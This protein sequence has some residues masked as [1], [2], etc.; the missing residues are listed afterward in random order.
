MSNIP[1][2]SPLQLGEEQE[3]SFRT[4]KAHWGYYA[5]ATDIA[6][7]AAETQVAILMSVLGPKAILL[8]HDLGLTE[9]EKKS[10]AAILQKLELKLTPQREKRTERTE[11]RNMKQLPEESYD[12][13]LKRLRNKVKHCAF[14]AAE[15]KEELKEQFVKGIR[16]SE[17]RKQLLRDEALSL[18]QMV[19]KAN[20]EK[21]IDEL[22]EAYDQLHCDPGEGGSKSALKVTTTKRL[23]KNC[24]FCGSLHGRKKE[25][26]PAWG[27]KCRKC[28]RMNHFES[29][30]KSGPKF[31]KAPK[32][33]K[34][35]RRGTVRKVEEETTSS[36]SD[37]SDIE[38]S[39][40]VDIFSVEKKS[41]SQMK[42]VVSLEVG[43]GYATT[44]KCQAD[45]GAMVNIISLRDLHKCV[46]KPSMAPTKVKL[47]CFGGQVIVP[48]GKVELPVRLK[49]KR[50]VLSFVV[51]KS[52]QK[53][54]LSASACITLGVIKVEHVGSVEVMLN[55]C[56][57]IVKEFDDVFDGD[58]CFDG[59]FKIEVDESVRPVQQK[60]RRIPVAYMGELKKT[61][62]DLEVR[63]I[64]EPVN[65]HAEWISNL[66]LVKR[67]SKLRLCLDPSELNSAIKRTRHQIPTVEEMLP[68]LQNAKVFSVLDAKNG[69][70]HLKLDD[71]SSEL[72]TFWTPFGT[73]RWMRMPFGISAA[74]EMF[75]KE[76]QQI[77]CGLKGT[78]CIADDILI[79]GVGD[80]MTEALEDHNRNLKAALV[81][82]RERGL[83]IN[84]SKMK[85]AMTEVPFFGHILTNTGVK[86]DPQKV[87]AVAEIESPKTKKELHTFL[88]LATYLGKFLPS[89]SEICAP[90]RN[91]VK[92]D[93][94]FVWNEQAESSFEQLKQLAVTA[95]VLRYFDRREKLTI[96][97][98]ASKA[99]VGCVLLQNGQPVVYGSRTLT[100]AESNYACIERECLAIVFACKR[101]EQ[102]VVGMPGVVVETD[103][104]PLVEIFKKPIHTAP[105]RLQRMMLALK[106][107]VVTVTYR[108]GS[109]MH[110]A[111]LL[112]RTAKRASTE[113]VDNEFEIYAIKSTESLLEYFA[114]INLAECL[115]LSDRRF[116]EIAA[117]TRKDP[118][119]QK[120]MKVLTEGWPERKEDIDDELLVYRTMKD[121]LTVQQ[122]VVLKADRVLIPKTLRQTFVKRLHRA[123]QGVEYTLRAARESMFW[124]GMSDQVTN[125]VQSCEACME[126]SSSQCAPPMSTH[127]IPKYPFQRVH[128]DLCEVSMEGCKTTMLVTADSYSDF[129]EVDILKSTSTATIVECCKRNFARHGVPEVVVS[130]NG[131]QFDNAS[132]R[133]FAQDWEFVH[134]T[135]SPYHQSG[136]GK[137]ESAVKQVKRLFKKTTRAGED[138]WQALLQQRNTPNKIGSSPTQRLLGRSTRN[139]IPVVTSK[140]KHI[141]Q[142]TE[143][144]KIVEHRKKVK[145]C[146]DRSTKPLPELQVGKEVVFQRRPD[147][148]KRWEKAVVLEKHPDKSVQLRAADGAV[149]RRS[150][151]H[152]KPFG[153]AVSGECRLEH[154][155]ETSPEQPNITERDIESGGVLERRS[156]GQQKQR[157]GNSQP[158]GTEL[159]R[160]S[161]AGQESMASTSQRVADTQRP[162][163]EIKRP[164]RLEDYVV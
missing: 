89:L 75:Q 14:G 117:E 2:P 106:R 161:P 77:I 18:E 15:Q 19:D 87:R 8:L 61:I 26:C 44:L 92:Q 140:L 40:F 97:C 71:S 88:G 10:T 36:E 118:V 66:V 120:L 59:E 141:F 73:Y 70:W 49:Q 129:V 128:L 6:K 131:P 142:P 27:K 93:V 45:T 107:Y 67:G 101:F 138:F 53:P 116:Q 115:N 123:H 164:K 3:E 98:D 154:R 162:K 163:R 56:E 112:S 109:E 136:N 52:K 102:Y 12:D 30:C 28:G 159:D 68:D 104:K 16:N 152:V 37:D 111:D 35:Q 38:E 100:K 54:L 72:T 127:E 39:N 124:P 47:R 105:I 24:F 55:S 29:V 119:L 41:K 13:F 158:G 34:R 48:V 122:G 76:Q 23:T 25:E 74:P 160:G 157:E 60:A 146:Y 78:R 62:S 17:L 4:F 133:K 42:I 137:A 58:G 143:A 139:S 150:A 155:R 33:K 65:K 148:D 121:E 114:E 110:V 79:Y 32:L 156:L 145:K 91:L 1:V 43:P 64:I 95:P 126:F 85:L 96:Q 82:F 144:D 99:G 9:E 20:A 151:V 153:R 149:L 147:T 11:F 132:F 83:K 21:K 69:F 31:K 50:E 81:R 80:T 63:G 113:G 22:V 51:V 46:K 103:H 130:D 86:P 135:S 94:D 57:A 90:L 134:S 5:I 108:K 84:R 7:K 125:A